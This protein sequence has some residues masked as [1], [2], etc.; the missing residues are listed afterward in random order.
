MRNLEHSPKQMRIS[1]VGHLSRMT[2]EA[3]SGHL[4]GDEAIPRGRGSGKTECE[5]ESLNFERVTNSYSI[6]TRRAQL[7][8]LGLLKMEDESDEVLE[9]GTGTGTGTD[10]DAEDYGYFNARLSLHQKTLHQSQKGR[11][12][13]STLPRENNGPDG[14]SQSPLDC[15]VAWWPFSFSFGHPRLENSES[16][17][18]TTA[19]C[20]RKNW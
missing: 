20:Q 6:A 5:C 11:L 3:S 10:A 12:S 2:T 19:S 17:S 16:G 1:R 9:P 18:S 4:L 7:A 8:H 15:S 13:T 14:S